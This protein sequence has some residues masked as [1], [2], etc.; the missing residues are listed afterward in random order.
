MLPWIL[1]TNKKRKKIS[2]PSWI[3][4]TEAKTCNQQPLKTHKITPATQGLQ[5]EKN[6]RIWLEKQGLTFVAAGVRNQ[7]GEIDLIMAQDQLAI[8]VEVRQRSHQQWG[9][10]LASINWRKRRKIVHAAQ[11]WWSGQGHLHFKNMRFDTLTY[12]GNSEKTPAKWIQAA[13]DGQGSV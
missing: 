8:V 10:A 1:K 11:W 4:P 9:G 5:A 13:F 3:A 2:K 7:Y 6:A 12:E